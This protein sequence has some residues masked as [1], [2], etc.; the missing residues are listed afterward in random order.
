MT[1]IH[2]IAG[3]VFVLF[4]WYCTQESRQHKKRKAKSNFRYINPLNQYDAMRAMKHHTTERQMKSGDVMIWSEAMQEYIIHTP[5]EEEKAKQ[6]DY[7][8]RKR[9]EDDTPLINPIKQ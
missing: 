2:I 9:S 1:P 8:D 3:I 7:E 6:K 5:T 4:V